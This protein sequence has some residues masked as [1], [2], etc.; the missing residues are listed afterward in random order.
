MGASMPESITLLNFELLPGMEE[1]VLRYL[2]LVNDHKQYPATRCA[3]DEN[4]Y[5][6]GVTSSSSMELMNNASMVVQEQTSVNAVN[7]S[8]VLLKFEAK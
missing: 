3:M 2:N 6:Y 8:I 7:T 1:P 5:M 4:I